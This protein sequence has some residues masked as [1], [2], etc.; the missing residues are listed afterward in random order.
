MEEVQEFERADYQQLLMRMRDKDGTKQVPNKQMIVMYNPNTP[1]SWVIDTFEQPINDDKY[2]IT[3]KFPDNA[4]KELVGLPKKWEIDRIEKIK[5]EGHEV[6]VPILI[7]GF[8][9]NYEDNKLLPM[10]TIAQIEGL[11]HTDIAEWRNYALGLAAERTG[12]V[13]TNIKIKELDLSTFE[14]SF[15]YGLD[16][17]FSE[18]PTA[19]IEFIICDKRKILYLNREVIY[20]TGLTNNDISYIIKSERITSQIIADSAEPKSI[21]ELY[22]NGINIVAAIKGPGSIATGIKKMKEYTIV[23]NPNCTNL[24][25][26]FDKYTFKVDKNGRV[27]EVIVDKDNHGIDAVRYGLSQQEYVHV[28][29]AI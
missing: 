25:N 6:E 1:T 13:F 9:S 7:K 10:E 23:I 11:K 17:G 27:T 21:E 29:K 28:V 19:L 16:W 22:L 20:A 3:M 15:R 8:R 4:H 18:D 2:N 5:W 24:I 14:N 26:E 12:K